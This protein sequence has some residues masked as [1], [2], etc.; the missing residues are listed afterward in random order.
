MVL[1]S[2]SLCFR[3]PQYP[4][5]YSLFKQ[6]HTIAYL[7]TYILH[8]IR[9]FGQTASVCESQ[10]GRRSSLTPRVY[11]LTSELDPGLLDWRCSVVQ[12]G[13][14]TLVV[15]TRPG[16]PK[17]VIPHTWI[18]ISPGRVCLVCIRGMPMA[19]MLVRTMRSLSPPFPCSNLCLSVCTASTKTPFD[20]RFPVA[21]D[22]HHNTSDPHGPILFLVSAF[23]FRPQV[24]PCVISSFSLI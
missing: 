21:H 10:Y 13:S 5:R 16:L 24:L 12:L 6:Y 22:Q 23:G 2:V 17:A 15:Y 1:V 9:K 18:S 7:P 19:D 11:R 14:R 8:F 3:Q 20:Q 4:P